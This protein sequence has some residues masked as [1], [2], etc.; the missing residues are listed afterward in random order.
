MNVLVTGG[1]GFIGSYL[2]EAYLSEG[3]TVV[4][5]DDF[6]TGH[7][8]NV[9]PG[10]IVERL[11][12]RDPRLPEVFERHR[13]EFVNHHAARADVRDSVKHPELYLDVNVRGGLNLL[14]AARRAKVRGIVFASSG[15]CSYGEPEY[16]PTDESHPLNP[17]DPYGTSKVAFELYLQTWFR[18]YALPYTIFRYPNIYGLRQDPFG[19]AAVAAIFA[20][21]MLRGLDV[22]IFGDGEQVRDFV[23]IEDIVRAN[24]LA[25]ARPANRAYNLGWGAGVSVNRIF[26]LLGELTAYD[27]A[28]IYEPPRLGEIS[29]SVLSSERIRADWGWRPE[30]SL[31]E[32]LRRTVEYLRTHVIAAN[33]PVTH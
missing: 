21:R 11:D 30:V 28:P 15:G 29:R 19:E 18:L 17:H 25:T 20:G 23:F 31:E 13:I 9:P 3:H 4:V 6:S 7:E 32:G 24:M 22:T 16:V 5:L 2:S 33:P 14:E 26:Q 27:R 12:V 8:S 10:V 1:A